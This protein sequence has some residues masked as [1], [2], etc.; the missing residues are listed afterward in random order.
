MTPPTSIPL[1]VSDLARGS[2]GLVTG[3]EGTSDTVE[4]L[5]AL[6]LVPGVAVRV[7]T[8]GVPMTVAV[9]ESRLALGRGWA[10]SILVVR[11]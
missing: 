2:R 6:G 11:S 8:E 4:R 7:V 3:V 9:G 1:R 10:E 5:A